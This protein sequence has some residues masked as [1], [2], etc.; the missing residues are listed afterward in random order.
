MQAQT[1]GRNREYRLNRIILGIVAG[2]GLVVAGIFGIQA[3]TDGQPA[4]ES[5]EL[6]EASPLTVAGPDTTT[7][8]LDRDGADVELPPVA[9]PA[10]GVGV[11]T[12]YLD[13][14]GAD[15][16]ESNWWSGSVYAGGVNEAAPGSDRGP[17]TTMLNLDRDGADVA[18]D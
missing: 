5:A 8:N 18:A 15:I 14:D 13:R 2:L 4:G 9:Q 16:P 10:G 7:L 11:T 12:L 1:T 17:D 6:R 3:L